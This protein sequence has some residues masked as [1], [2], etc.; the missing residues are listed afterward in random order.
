[1]KAVRLYSKNG[2]ATEHELV[3]ILLESLVPVI[4]DYEREGNTEE[5]EDV[6]WGG[7]EGVLRYLECPQ[8]PSAAEL[9]FMD[10]IAWKRDELWQ[11]I[12]ANR[13]PD[14]VSLDGG[15]PKGLAAHQLIPDTVWLSHIL[16]RGNEAPYVFSRVNQVLFSPVDVIMA[17]PSA[18]VEPHEDFVDQL[19]S[20][21][22]AYIRGEKQEKEKRA[23]EIWEHY[24]RILQPYPTDLTLFQNWLAVLVRNLGMG[25][26]YDRI[27]SN[28]PLVMSIPAGSDEIVEWDPLEGLE[29][30]DE[31]SG[32]RDRAHSPSS[33]TVLNLRTSSYDLIS[34]E[35]SLGPEASRDNLLSIWKVEPHS[36]RNVPKKSFTPTREAVILS[37]LLFLDTFTKDS[38]ILRSKF[39]DEEY[40]RY[41]AVYLSDEFLRRLDHAKSRDSMT[42]A[43]HAL[44]VFGRDVPSSLLRDLI[45]S[46]MDALKADPHAR[47]YPELVWCTFQLLKVL[48]LTNQP[49]VIVDVIL[50]VWK[51]FPNDSSYHRAVC[52]VKIGRV[53]T[54]DQARAFMHNF[55]IY[56]C[57]ALR[58]QRQ[59]DNDETKP[60]IKVTTVKMLA[61]SLA[62]PEFLPQAMCL[63]TL[64][65]IY[66]TSRHIDIRVAVFNSMLEMISRNNDADSYMH[67]SSIALSA[68]Q[69]SE[70]DTTTEEDWRAAELGGPLPIVDADSDRPILNIA[71]QDASRKLPES[72][73]ADY[74]HRVILPL[75]H[76][77]TSQHV[78][79]MS[80]FLGKLGLSLSD[81]G[82]SNDEVGPFSQTL[83]NT[84]FS[85]W[86]KHLPD[87]YLKTQQ[88]SLA[89]SCR[90]Y[91][92]FNRIAERFATT[93]DPIR[94]NSNAREHWENYLR[95][96]RDQAPFLHLDK[97]LA[98][99][100]DVSGGITAE[101]IIQEYILRARIII[102]HPVRYDNALDK[103]VLRPGFPLEILHNLRRRR[104]G[105]LN[106]NTAHRE[107]LYTRITGLMEKIVRLIEEI[108]RDG[109]VSDL[110]SYPVTLPT[111][112][113]CEIVLLP[114]PRYNP[115]SSAWVLD[116]FA[117]GLTGL[118]R[119]YRDD[120]ALLMEIDFLN[121][122]IGEIREEDAATCAILIG[123]IDSP[124]GGLGP[125]ESWV[126]V[127]LAQTSLKNVTARGIQSRR[128][129]KD[130]VGTWKAS[131]HE[132]VRQIGWVVDGSIN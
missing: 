46:F 110:R 35:S 55:S 41:P 73:R 74:T 12:R 101:T 77:S 99:D 78:R 70:R 33:P 44:R 119:K 66:S 127:K 45:Y 26:V 48:L 111:P 104:S 123:K 49:Q 50:R 58:Q 42:H 36:L 28:K 14:I 89:L 113:Q 91:S 56:V 90:C 130:M 67:F 34:D 8:N 76:K 72:L 21:I 100:S 117:T 1:M 39:P 18:D 109:W 62:E 88:H 47:I 57:N 31:M 15:L 64:R 81:L 122:V 10:R 108:R 103:Y 75:L 129:I 120:P 27:R 87:A 3:D 25:R 37:A 82:L 16:E 43:I 80:C 53:V 86:W 4:M 17:V 65:D 94:R 97:L 105:Y 40:P 121:K 5:H 118:I 92:S 106:E 63:N 112:L 6:L 11:Q 79:W 52:L 132:L 54:P 107:V 115:V 32:M 60:L 85:S 102:R 131:S 95:Y 128:N 38:R 93:S 2:L 114:S 23:M 13:D 124:E 98:I 30:G 29:D 96:H 7:P 24:S 20:L 71:V 59:P 19:E 22:E 84:V 116:E 68:A 51:D 61:Q 83:V 69:P 126:R 125:V 9:A